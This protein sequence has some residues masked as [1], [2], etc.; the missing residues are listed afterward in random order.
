MQDSTHGRLAANAMAFIDEAAREINVKVVWYSASPMTAA[1]LVRFVSDRTRADLKRVQELD[2]G[3]GSTVTLLQFVPAALGTLRGYATRFHFYAIETQEGG[4][5][6]D[7]ACLLLFKGADACVFVGGAN[8]AKALARVDGALA[9][10]GCV[11]VVSAFAVEAG[12]AGAVADRGRALGFPDADCFAVDPA[13]GTGVFDVVKAVAKKLLGSLA[14]HDI[15]GRPTPAPH[16]LPLAVTPDPTARALAE[17]QEGLDAWQCGVHEKVVWVLGYEETRITPSDVPDGYPP[18]T[19]HVIRA[20]SSDGFTLVTNGFS[21][22]PG[23]RVELR[24]DTLRHGW[25]I[26]MALSFL[27]RVRQRQL[28]D[29]GPPW[30]PFDLVTTSEAPIFG[31]QHFVLLPGGSVH[32]GDELVLILRV[33]PITP[34][35]HAQLS[36]KVV[37]DQVSAWLSASTT[38]LLDRWLPALEHERAFLDA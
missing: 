28:W 35:E 8:E 13:S 4:L 5:E 15:G 27:G 25:Q 22:Q 17:L 1:G 30:R 14:G 21:R 6:S 33:A 2:I 29:G 10:N 37:G 23:E 12:G 36:G 18:H 16:T 19:V 38:P 7:A 20:T 31:M 11:D 9:A 32:V 34:A 3:G 26:A 24:A